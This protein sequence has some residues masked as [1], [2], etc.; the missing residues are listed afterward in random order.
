MVDSSPSPGGPS[1]RERGRRGEALAERFLVE[2]GYR[3]VARNVN[4]RHAELDLVAL[5]GRVLCFVEVRARSGTAFGS[6]EE[7][8]D[9]RKQRKLVQGARAYLARGPLPRHER[10]RFDVVAIDTTPVP[11]RVR[12]IR[13]A[14][15]A[16]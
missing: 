14:F 8:V 15:Q 3:I 2:L 4:L 11:P 7:S 13:D 16:D 6:A 5:D 1:T 10:L 12:L 9:R